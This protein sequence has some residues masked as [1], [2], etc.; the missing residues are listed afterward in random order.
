[1]M[2]GKPIQAKH[3][4]PRTI[5]GLSLGREQKSETLDVIAAQI[6]DA[7]ICTTPSQD[8]TPA[9]Y[10]DCFFLSFFP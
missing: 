3:T 5:G 6:S 9:V 4:G 7:C 1:M 8:F 10:Y 2:P